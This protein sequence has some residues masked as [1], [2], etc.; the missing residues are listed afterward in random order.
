MG[1]GVQVW[2]VR[3]GGFGAAGLGLGVAGVKG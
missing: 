2:R 1:I 3:G